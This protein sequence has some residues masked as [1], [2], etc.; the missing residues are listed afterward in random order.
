MARFKRPKPLAACS[1]CRALT[2]LHVLV[3]HRCDSVVN[4]RRCPGIY[5]SDLSF[6]WDQCQAC[7]ATGYVGSKVC[8]ECA[9]MGWR[10]T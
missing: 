7:D 1:E 9:G 3:N 6:V 8:V 5:H 4:G 10:L 2:D